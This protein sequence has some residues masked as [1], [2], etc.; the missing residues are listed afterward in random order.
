MLSLFL[1][2]T[3][4]LDLKKNKKK[5]KKVTVVRALQVTI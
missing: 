5:E 3:N 2:K 1:N 4:E